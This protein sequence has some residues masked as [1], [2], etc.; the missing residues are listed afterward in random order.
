MTNLSRF[1]A[2]LSGKSSDEC[3]R[4]HGV[5]MPDGPQKWPARKNS[6]RVRGQRDSLSVALMRKYFTFAFSEIV[7]VCRHPAS[8]KRGVR[9]IVTIRGVRGAVGASGRSVFNHADERIRCAR[10][11]VWSWSPGAETKVAELGEFSGSTGARK[12]VP[13]ESAYKPFSHRAGK[14]GLSG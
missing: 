13:G 1:Q 8:S 6:F 12:P 7:I 2:W 11:V 3:K 4:H 9:A 14:A 5:R 10:E